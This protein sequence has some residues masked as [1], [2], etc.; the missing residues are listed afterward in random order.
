MS[1]DNRFKKSIAFQRLERSARHCANIE[2]II[3]IIVINND[4]DIVN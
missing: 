1:S 3:D 4:F 2:S